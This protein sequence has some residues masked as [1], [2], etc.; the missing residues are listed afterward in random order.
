VKEVEK[1]KVVNSRSYSLVVTANGDHRNGV[2]RTGSRVPVNVAAM[3]P[4]QY[5]YMDVGVDIDT[6]DIRESQGQLL[7][8]IVAEVSSL[9]ERAESAPPVV[10]RNRWESDV[11]VPVG[12]AVT[13][14]SSDDV[15]STRTMQLDL[16]AMPIAT[17]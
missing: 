10:R 11:T 2:I 15:A 16:K 4:A 9:G 5:Q 13:V 1:S 14:F 12:K 6:R 3:A 8:H 17:K 7:L